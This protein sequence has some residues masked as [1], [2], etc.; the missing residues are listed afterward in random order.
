MILKGWLILREEED[1]ADPAVAGIFGIF[2]DERNSVRITRDPGKSAGIHAEFFE[3]LLGGE[4]PFGR[5]LPV[6]VR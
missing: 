2:L 1:D 5:E 6:A 3:L 4:G